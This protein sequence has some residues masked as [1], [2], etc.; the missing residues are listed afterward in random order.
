MFGKFTWVVLR[1]DCE[2]GLTLTYATHKSTYICG[3]RYIFQ[4]EQ[5]E[6]LG[7][8]L[9]RK[10]SLVSTYR[11]LFGMYYIV[12]LKPCDLSVQGGL[13]CK[14]THVRGTNL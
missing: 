2:L 7:I 10:V 8:N 12:Q 1:E 6:R 13:D 14:Q 5:Q 4:A 3:S 11:T 9:S